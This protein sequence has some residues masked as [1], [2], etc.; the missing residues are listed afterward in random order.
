MVPILGPKMTPKR[1]QKDPKKGLPRAR[2]EIPTRFLR[3]LYW[4]RGICIGGLSDSFTKFPGFWS[5]FDPKMGHFW[6]NTS[7]MGRSLRRSKKRGHLR[8]APSGPRWG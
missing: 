5:F 2:A 1:G 3:D 4:D 8:G 6:G 7:L